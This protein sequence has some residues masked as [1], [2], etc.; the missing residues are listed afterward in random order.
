MSPLEKFKLFR[1]K[2]DAT[3]NVRCV[4]LMIVVSLLLHAEFGRNDH[5]KDA[6]YFI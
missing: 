3:V 4:V 2:N 6:P 1:L 5:R